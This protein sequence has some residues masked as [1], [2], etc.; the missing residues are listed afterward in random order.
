VTAPARAAPVAFG[1]QTP[2]RQAE[3]DPNGQEVRQRQGLLP[4]DG[5]L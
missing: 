2:A 3:D 4:G 1:Q 5:L